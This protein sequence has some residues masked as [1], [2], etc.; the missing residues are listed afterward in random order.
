MR[1]RAGKTIAGQAIV[2]MHRHA[3]R[4]PVTDFVGAIRNATA[5]DW[6]VENDWFEFGNSHG[7]PIRQRRLEN[8]GEGA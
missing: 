2:C 8:I 5:R 1:V 4:A 3:G 6:R 7:M